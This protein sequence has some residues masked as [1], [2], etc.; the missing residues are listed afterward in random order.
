MDELKYKD[1]KFTVNGIDVSNVSATTEISAN[2]SQ[3]SVIDNPEY[4][5]V[6]IDEENRI[7]SAVRRDGTK[8]INKIV[9]PTI[10][11]INNRI[12]DNE[13]DISKIKDAIKGKNY[14]TKIWGFN[15]F[16]TNTNWN[17]SDN[18]KTA[19]TEIKGPENMLIFDGYSY[20]DKNNICADFTASGSTFECILGKWSQLSGTIFGFGYDGDISY[21][22]TYLVY[23]PIKN[24]DFIE[25]F[26]GDIFTFSLLGQKNVYNVMAYNSDYEPLIDLSNM[27]KSKTGTYVVP[28]GVKYLNFY[29]FDDSSNYV[30]CESLGINLGNSNLESSGYCYL[31]NGT[32]QSCSTTVPCMQN[33]YQLLNVSLKENETFSVRIMKRT[34]NVSYYNI[35]IRDRYGNCDT[36]KNIGTSS[37][38][39]GD[40]TNEGNGSYV[41]YCWGS[42]CTYLMKGTSLKVENLSFTY[43][44]KDE[45]KTIII[46]HS[47]IEGNS[48]SDQKD[49]RFSYL[50][51]EDL[52]LDN[53]LILGVGGETTTGTLK[54]ID[55]Y[56]K[57]FSNSKY[58]LI[59]LGGNDILR[60]S[61]E[62]NQM[63]FYNNC[64]KIN[65]KLTNVGIQPIWLTVNYGLMMKYQDITNSSEA[66]MVI[67]G[68]DYTVVSENLA[69]YSERDIKNKFADNIPNYCY[70]E[71]EGKVYKFI[72]Y[73]FTLTKE[74]DI[75]NDLMLKNLNCVE[76][77][78]CFVNSN[79]DEDPNKYLNDGIHPSTLGH[80][81]IY[82]AIKAQAGYLFY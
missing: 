50:V 29:A 61:S 19:Y 74:N 42:L 39:G 75:V 51:A 17:I 79:G 11:N 36:F 2:T 16:I 64:L 82:Q 48:I 73:S 7:I 33:K 68:G 55:K 52:G 20:E 28:S 23:Y 15:E 44:I 12:S 3:F 71:N 49:K 56:C 46:G 13:S 70:Y 21:L 14:Q 62:S 45:L 41:G 47:Y 25:V 76:I 78:D 58:C 67:S 5:E 22:S 40:T 4:A 24:T 8:F 27:Y 26:E 31:G 69:S 77:R 38:T 72:K 35:E 10:T 66:N 34:E 53:T 60:N 6:V 81:L 37:I 32:I 57:W 1:G 59:N 65:E 54:Y 43:P 9:S 30:K 63:R 80:A 18:N